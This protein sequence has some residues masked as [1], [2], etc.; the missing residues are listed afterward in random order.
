MSYLLALVFALLWTAAGQSAT[1]EGQSATDEA[2]HVAAE[3]D[4]VDFSM[5]NIKRGK[6]LFTVHCVSCHG[7]DGRGDT[8]MREF[9][10][11]P[12]ADLSD[13]QWTY[14]GSDA[15]LF[16]V[17]KEGRLARDMPAFKETLSDQ[18]IWQVV[19]YMRYL[20]GER[21]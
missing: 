4:A 9:L 19:I 11:T 8:E 3:Q 1:D 2:E 17:V 12:P 6:Q 7:M 10:K 16:D 21:P 20:G 15:V 5:S 13:D 14:S 18:R